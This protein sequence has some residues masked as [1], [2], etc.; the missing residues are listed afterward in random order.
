MSRAIIKLDQIYRKK[1]R[2]ERKRALWSGQASFGGD[3]DG[4]DGG[5]GG[6]GI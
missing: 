2:R 1:E 4:G 6:G 3:L 5:G